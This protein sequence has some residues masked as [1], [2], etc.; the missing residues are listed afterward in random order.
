MKLEEVIRYQESFIKNVIQRCI[1]NKHPMVKDVEI[2]TGKERCDSLLIPYP[3]IY[4]YT[5]NIVY[6]PDDYC[7][8]TYLTIRDEIKFIVRLFFDENEHLKAIWRV[9]PTDFRY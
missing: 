7:E 2:K 3:Y 6:S 1:T 4:Y 5:V 9:T 8:Q